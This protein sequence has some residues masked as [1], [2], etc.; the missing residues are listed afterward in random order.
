MSID[1][2][3]LLIILSGFIIGP[4]ALAFYFYFNKTKLITEKTQ[5]QISIIFVVFIVVSMLIIS[6]LFTLKSDDMSFWSTFFNFLKNP[7]LIGL[8]IMLVFIPIYNRLYI[9]HC[10]KKSKWQDN[11][12]E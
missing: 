2:F 5:R 1:V 12:K 8:C 11:E 6:L 3:I 7:S 10:R 4:F 9:R